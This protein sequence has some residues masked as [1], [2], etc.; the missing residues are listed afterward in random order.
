M[1]PGGEKKVFNARLKA[2]PEAFFFYDRKHATARD[3]DVPLFV[4]RDGRD[5]LPGLNE[6]IDRF[7]AKA[8]ARNLPITVVN[9][10]DA[11][12]AFDI[13]RDSETSRDIIGRLLGFL[14]LHLL[15]YA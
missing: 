5:E 6:S 4:V 13:M 11:P 10:A 14:R 3:Q 8:L 9:H 12:H 2:L 15:A 1:I 7:V